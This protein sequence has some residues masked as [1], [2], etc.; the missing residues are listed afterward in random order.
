MRRQPQNPLGIECSSKLAAGSQRQF[1]RL[2]RLVV[3]HYNNHRLFGGARKERNVER[4]RGRS[5]SRD[6][7]TPRSKAQVPAYAIECG[8]LLQLREDFADK[9]ED[10]VELILP[11]QSEDAVKAVS[12]NAIRRLWVNVLE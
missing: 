2:S 11:A 1:Q 8:G 5:Q 3:R 4:P 10:H 12:M 6:T 9:R 7:P